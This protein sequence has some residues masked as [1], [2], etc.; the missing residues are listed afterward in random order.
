MQ[1]FS[2]CKSVREIQPEIKFLN[3]PG[4]II[5]LVSACLRPEKEEEEE[6][7]KVISHFR[8]AA[9]KVALFGEPLHVLIFTFSECSDFPGKESDLIPLPVNPPPKIKINYLGKHKAKKRDAFK[10]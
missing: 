5:Q 1:F 2:L 4:T 7:E 10:L 9:I 3:E 8:P 6:E